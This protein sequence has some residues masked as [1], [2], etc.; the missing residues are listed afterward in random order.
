MATKSGSTYEELQ[1]SNVLALPSRGTLRVY[2][3]AIKPT[4][5]FNPKVIAEL[6]SLT[7]DFSNLQRYISLASDEIK[8][9]S[10]IVH[11]R[12]IGKLIGYVDLGDLDIN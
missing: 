10:N 2:R 9:Q 6:C 12:Y 11:D 7:K 1:N 3:N 8:I 5:R 4:V